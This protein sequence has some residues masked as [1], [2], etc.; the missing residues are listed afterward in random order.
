MEKK[1]KRKIKNEKE[2]LSPPLSVL[3][4]ILN[5]YSLP[6]W[7]SSY[8]SEIATMQQ[9]DSTAYKLKPRL[10]HKSAYFQV[11]FH[12]LLFLV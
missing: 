4:D 12:R 11:Y 5:Q 2:K 8:L 3:T 6:S 10:F 1:I 9:T 7:T